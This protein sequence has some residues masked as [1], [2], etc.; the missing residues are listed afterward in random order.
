MKRLAVALTCTT[1]LFTLVGCGN[2]DDEKAAKSLATSLTKGGQFGDKKDEAD[3]IG[4]EMVDSIGIEDLQKSGLLTKDLTVDESISDIKMAKADAENAAKSITGCTDTE[5]LYE[6]LL[7][8]SAQLKPAVK[9]CVTDFITK[10]VVQKVLAAEF[11]GDTS[12]RETLLQKPMVE[13][14]KKD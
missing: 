7:T 6:E 8:S 11:A 2:Q 4:K 5:A 10:D 3:C 9:K 14:S 1:L 12:A 13:C